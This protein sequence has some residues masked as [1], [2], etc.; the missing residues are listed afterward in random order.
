MPA[1]PYQCHSC[2]A[3]FDIIKSVDHFDREE[4]CTK[5]GGK[6]LVR[7]IAKSNLEKS[8][9]VQ[10]YYEPTLGCI[11]KSKSQ[12]AQILKDKGLEEVGTT[13]ADSMYKDL[14]LQREKRLAREWDEL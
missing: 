11:I 6:D 7:Y 8:S 12:R 10:P 2:S 14:E 9:M 3:E 5:C 4:Q 13:S 1:Y